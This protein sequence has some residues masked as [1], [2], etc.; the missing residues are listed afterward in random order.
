VSGL[1]AVLPIARGMI[2]FI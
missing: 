1:P 2:N